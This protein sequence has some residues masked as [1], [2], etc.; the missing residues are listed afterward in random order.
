ML[1]KERKEK[2][3]YKKEGEGGGEYYLH[4]NKRTMAGL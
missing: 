4:A 2:K 1:N 3:I